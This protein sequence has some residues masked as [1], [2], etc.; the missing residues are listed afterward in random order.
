VTSDQDTVVIRRATSEDGALLLAWRNDPITRKMF[1]HQKEVL[2]E[3]HR[4]W[5]DETLNRDDRVLL[6]GEVL[7]QRPIGVVRF[8]ISQGQSFAEISITIAPQARGRG[9]A[10]RLLRSAIAHFS[11][12]SHPQF[13]RIRLI[14]RIRHENAASVACFRRVGFSVISEDDEY[15]ELALDQQ[16]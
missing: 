2:L 14:A 10:S 5:L 9:F 3:E 16:Q 15:V 7:D 6:I 11:A 1:V 13:S 12:G 4:A 8:D